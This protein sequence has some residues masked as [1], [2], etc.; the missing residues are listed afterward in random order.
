[1]S[2]VTLFH[3]SDIHFGI[4]DDAAHRWFAEAVERERP[5][6]VICTGDITQRARHREWAA[7]QNWFASLFAPVVV[8]VGNHDMP[9]Y[10][11]GERF[12]TPFKRFQR[13][14]DAVEQKV[15]L[16]GIRLV[17]LRTTVRV[18]GRFPWSDG[19]VTDAALEHAV[20]RVQQVADGQSIVIVYGHHPLVT[21]PLGAPNPT[22]GGDVAFRA[23]ALAGANVVLSGHVHDPFDFTL[24]AE[25]RPLRLVGA[26]T[27]SRRLRRSGPSYNVLR[28]APEC[29]MTVEHRHFQE[30]AFS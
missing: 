1:M 13:F 22:I 25:G 8:E 28:Y 17:P 21:G 26:G 7:A 16:P 29:G 30:A 3:V 11:L 2:G 18:Q 23:L 5:D 20:R 6:A 9:Y 4:E 27:L 15:E 14:S 12:L 24:E 19:V 10:N